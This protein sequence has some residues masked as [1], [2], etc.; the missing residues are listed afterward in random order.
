MKYVLTNE[1]V[2]LSNKQEDEFF[3]LVMWRYYFQIEFYL[4]NQI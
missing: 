1:L 2:K 4:D 3:D